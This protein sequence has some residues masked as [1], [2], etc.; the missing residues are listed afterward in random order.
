[1]IR[2]HIF[3]E[4]R[5]MI[6]E[7]ISMLNPLES[8]LLDLVGLI[9]QQSGVVAIGLAGGE[10]ALPLPGESDLDIFVFCTSLPE[11]EQRSRSFGIF[12]QRFTE[13]QP[14]VKKD[15]YWGLQDF[16][17][18]RGV[19]T[20]LLNFTVEDVE[21]ELRSILS[22]DQPDRRE[23]GYFPIGR[24]ATYLSMRKLYDPTDFIGSLQA[25]LTPYPD[26]LAKSLIAFHLNQLDDTEDLDRAAQRQDILFYHFALDIAL[27]HFLQALF[28]L[29]RVYFPSRKRSLDYIH[30]FK[31][32][33]A[34]CEIALLRVLAL[35]GNP[36]TLV[37]S[38]QEFAQLVAQLK[39]CIHS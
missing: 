15:P 25:Q 24:C 39:G 5:S 6:H 37:E 4:L 31:R 21:Q 32:S 19:E 8:D 29:N 13:V 17:V 11:P 2:S 16:L 14:G 9:T 12:H 28:A 30:S 27:D 26:H 22:G 1:M 35:A 3:N 34:Q 7:R 36:E 20:W 33:P 23:N 10:R 18:L 38:K